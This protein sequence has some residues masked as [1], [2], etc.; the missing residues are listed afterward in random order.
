[1]IGIYRIVNKINTNCYYG[2]SKNIEKRWIRHKK[3][4][5][6]HT[7]INCILQ[8]AWDKYGEMNFSFEIIEECSISELLLKEQCYLDLKPAYNIGLNSS[9][10]DNLTNNPKKEEIIKK[11]KNTL[12]KRYCLMTETEKKEKFSKPMSKNPNWKGGK[13]TYCNCGSEMKAKSKTCGKCRPRCGEKNPFFNKKHSEDFKKKLSKNKKNKYYGKQNI[14]VIIN[15]I[16]YSSSGEASKKL[17]IPSVTIR[18]RILSKNPK[19]RNYQYTEIEKKSHT[20]KE[21][22]KRLSLSQKGKKRNFNKPFFIDNIEYRT[23]KDAS[24]KLGIHPTTIK[25]RLTSNNFE[26][27]QYK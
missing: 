18:W 1:M 7:H 24:D 12:N 3:Q 23:L 16:K 8:R 14:P 5:N 20:I 9:G 13:K 27:Y 17:C 21:Q 19:F 10:G 26:N 11:I 2:S 4:L 15:N 6:D 25:G 22:K